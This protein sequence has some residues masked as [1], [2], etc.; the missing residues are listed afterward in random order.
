[1]DD[2]E[3]Y[4]NATPR[5]DFVLTKSLLLNQRDYFEKSLSA[6]P[7]DDA[8][9]AIKLFRQVGPLDPSPEMEQLVNK[10]FSALDSEIA[11]KNG[12]TSIKTE[13]KKEQ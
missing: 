7:Y 1:M 5:G 6:L 9:A 12:V 10:R 2:G 11:A 4:N 3:G 13:T 8:V